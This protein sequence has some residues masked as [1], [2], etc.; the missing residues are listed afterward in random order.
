MTVLEVPAARD[1]L[2]LVDGF[3]EDG[4]RL[5][6][7]P[8]LLRAP[9]L[10]TVMD[11][12]GLIE[13]GQRQHFETGTG[14]L[15]IESGY[16]WKSWI[17]PSTKPIEAFLPE[18]L[19][20]KPEELRPLIRLTPTGRVAAARLNISKDENY[21]SRARADEI[22][23]E[24]SFDLDA[25]VLIWFGEK[26]GLT[27]NG[28]AVVKIFFDAWKKRQPKVSLDQLRSSVDS[29]ALDE[30][31]IKV[32]QRAREGKKLTD[33]VW[34]VIE[35]VGKGIYQLDD[36]PKNQKSPAKSPGA[37]RDNPPPPLQ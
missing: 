8:V 13:F 16:W 5:D 27:K 26:Y 32:F 11:A 12:D 25:R 3:G 37:P 34:G 10:L 28:A 29:N 22:V 30:S 19:Q 17:G 18:L 6:L 23:P 14:E 31:L 36:P 20:K 9:N 2:T 24:C 1:L 7:I 35:S 15:I 4:L 21:L 33:P